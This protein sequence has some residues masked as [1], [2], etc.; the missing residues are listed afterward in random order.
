MKYPIKNLDMTTMVTSLNSFVQKGYT[1]DY[2]ATSSGLKAL[3]TGKFYLPQEVVV[4]DFQRFEGTSDP[5]DESI[6]YVIETNDGGKGTL[7]DA[8][9]PAS[10][11]QVT[12]FMQQVEEISKM[13]DVKNDDKQ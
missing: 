5:G 7:V 12:S 6:L 11:T 4:V 2:K 1:E 3:K 9:G 8:F 13:T 10:D